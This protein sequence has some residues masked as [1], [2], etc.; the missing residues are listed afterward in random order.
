MQMTLFVAQ[1]S[2]SLLLLAG[3]LL[4]PNGS[5]LGSNWGGGGESYHTKRGLEKVIFMLTIIAAVLF[6]LM[7]VILLWQRR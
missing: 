2:V 3:I 7:A 1:L 5:G 4:Q 6:I